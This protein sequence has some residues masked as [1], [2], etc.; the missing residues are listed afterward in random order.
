MK[1]DD[2]LP[3]TM[4]DREPDSFDDFL[5]WVFVFLSAVGTGTMFWM[6]FKGFAFVI[7]RM[8]HAA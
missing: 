7:R 8:A 1:N 6:L 2:D 4:E 3:I 5:W